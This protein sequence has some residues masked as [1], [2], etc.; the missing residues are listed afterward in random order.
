MT[1]SPVM[2][3]IDWG[4]SAFR[5][6]AI[7]AGGEVLD[8]IAS[9]SGI[10]A[11]PGGDF[12]AALEAS[13][14]PWL[15]L[16][17]DLPILA[18]GMITSRNGWI[19]TPYLPL[20]LDAAALA[21]A[22]VPY[23]TTRGRRIWFVTGALGDPP[24]G[25]PDVMRGEETEIVGHL[26]AG[27]GDGLYLLPGTHSKWAQ[28]AGGRVTAFRSC[29]TG[30]VFALLRD[31]SI[32]G[33]LAVPGTPSADA[34]ARGLAAGQAPG[35]LLAR[36]FSAR[37]L[38]LLGRLAPED[39]ADYLSGLM[40]GDEVAAMLREGAPEGSVTVIGRGDLAARY[41]R[42]LEACGVVARIAAP[43]MARAGLVEIARRAGLMA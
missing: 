9:G 4:T 22:L 31:Q 37:T 35:A 1:A 39:I 8:E 27:G 42:A 40:I 41:G 16:A 12:E 13:L 5:A 15:T 21:A 18:S 17:P 24:G 7:G 23:R 6:W 19:E 3:A 25:T 36:V 38:A 32:L 14:G 2:I 20:P 11:V 28:V 43:G 26:A 33:R 30:E 10:L 29:M 34:F